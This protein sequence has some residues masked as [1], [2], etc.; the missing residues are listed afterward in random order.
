MFKSMI[1][2]VAM[3]ALPGLTYAG[4]VITRDTSQSSAF[5]LNKTNVTPEFLDA[6]AIS[7][8]AMLKAPT[9]EH[10]GYH[11]VGTGVWK[12]DIFSCMYNDLAGI[13]WDVEI[14]EKDGIPGLY[15]IENPYGNCPIDFIPKGDW[16]D[17]IVHTETPGQCYMEYTM[18]G[19]TIKYANKDQEIGI[20]DQAGY[21][22]TQSWIDIVS[23][24]F[25]W[26]LA[27]SA[28]VEDGAIVFPKD[29]V[30]LYRDGTKYKANRNGYHRILLPSGK[31]YSLE[32][33]AQTCID[34]ETFDFT[35]RSGA[36]VAT[37]KYAILSGLWQMNE[38]L[39]KAMAD[40]C[41]ALSTTSGDFMITI[42][43]PVD[44]LN[45]TLL[46][47]AYDAEG[48][49]V[50]GTHAWMLH[51]HNDA[52]D[53]QAC[54]TATY[55]DDIITSYFG[56]SLESDKHAS[57]KV[58][59]E[60]S[61]SQPGLFRLVNPYGEGT[62]YD[63][64]N[65]HDYEHDHY[66]VIDAINPKRV[67]VRPSSLGFD[68][69]SY[70]IYTMSTAQFLLD[71]YN[72]TEE[73]VAQY[74]GKYD[75]ENGIIALP[76]NA[77]LSGDTKTLNVEYGNKSGKFRVAFDGTDGTADIETTDTDSDDEYFTLQGVKVAAPSSP[78]VY[79]RRAGST[80]TK[81]IVK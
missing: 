41:V 63:F 47:A 49:L 74:W 15:L 81:V 78:G 67:Y 42:S 32:L 21:Y 12:D 60:Q 3:A 61:V 50:E 53:W 48:N 30:F 4:N 23:D 54:G 10:E 38:E 16:A 45:Y 76:E 51:S 56:F 22:A 79:L 39:G 75:K 37:V 52:A 57:Y 1:A 80:N 34:G 2:M 5:E 58:D 40:E 44:V 55:T 24:I 11:Y 7:L 17:I 66:L 27:P 31:D 46:I 43:E 35:L 25:D 9:K 77:L 20:S 6:T 8:N 28:T 65:S 59:V 36:D 72:A 18:L 19:C 70:G 71:N 14:F 33:T 62:Y 73:D 29:N 69:V 13:S 68:F 64:G 26:G